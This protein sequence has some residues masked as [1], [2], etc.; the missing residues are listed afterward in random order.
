M[1][2]LVDWILAIVCV[3]SLVRSFSAETSSLEMIG[4]LAM[5][6]LS[7]L[8]IVALHLRTHGV[9]EWIQPQDRP[10]EVRPVAPRTLGMKK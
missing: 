3:V 6:V 2:R 8:L 5:A 9:P 4:Y 10:V 1:K 7:G